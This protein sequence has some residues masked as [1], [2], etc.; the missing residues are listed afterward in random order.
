MAYAANEGRSPFRLEG[1]CDCNYIYHRLE[2]GPLIIRCDHCRWCQRESGSAFAIDAIIQ[3][4]RVTHL[5]AEPELMN[6]PSESGGSQLFARCP[7]D[8]ISV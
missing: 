3:Q 6:T 1:G 7:R 2:S 8:E 5:G 4:D